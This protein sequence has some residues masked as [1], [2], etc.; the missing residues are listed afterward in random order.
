M[1]PNRGQYRGRFAPSP[2]G[3]LHAGSLT[4]ALAS[5]LD[6]RAAGGAWIIRI[7]DLDPPRIVPGAAQRILEA[8]VR[9][10]LESDEPVVFQSARGELYQAA[11]ARLQAAGLIYGCACSRR[12][13]D[14]VIEAQAGWPAGV[15]PRTCA[16]GA[17]PNKPIR[18]YRLRVPDA[19]S[20]FTDRAAGPFMQH[21]TNDVGDFVVKRADGLWAYQLAV[22]VDD[23]EQKITDIVRGADLF[24]NTPRQIYLQR[25]LGF[26]TPRY[27]HVPLVLNTAGEKLSK[28]TG[29]TE[30]DTAHPLTALNRAALHLGLPD[31]AAHSI[32]AFLRLAID[33]WREKRQP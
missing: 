21:M 24:D 12:D 33:S 14:E 32:E 20:R 26:S 18:A 15:Y 3:P 8:L 31:F 25:A 2:T 10:G 5:W 4:T 29:A 7:E 9:C 6:A 16:A 27:L 1:T 23:A 17:A 13:V 30:L 19:K 22:V 11:F 28:Q